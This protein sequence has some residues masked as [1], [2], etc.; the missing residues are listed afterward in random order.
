MSNL[1]HLIENTLIAMED[2]KLCSEDIR[3]CIKNDI[4]LPNISLSVDEVL[5]ICQY[6]K[7]TWCASCTKTAEHIVENN[8]CPYCGYD[9]RNENDT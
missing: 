1:E 2:D 9:R 7:Y 6:V 4:N 8:I 5:E 3:E